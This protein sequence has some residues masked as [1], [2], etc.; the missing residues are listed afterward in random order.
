[1][2]FGINTR[3]RDLKFLSFPPENS[4]RI[5]ADGAPVLPA[6]SKRSHISNALC[7]MP[8]IK[9]VQSK[10]IKNYEKLLVIEF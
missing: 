10:T 8:L 6:R 1:M 2:L 9:N 4:D 7:S 3:Y 5:A